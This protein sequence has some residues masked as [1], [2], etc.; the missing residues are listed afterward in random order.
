[1]LTSYQRIMANHR[2]AQRVAPAPAN[3]SVRLKMLAARLEREDA[4]DLSEA[5]PGAVVAL[6]A[7]RAAARDQATA[8]LNELGESV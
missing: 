3:T 2:K 5:I 8:Q 7:S 1:V 6:T 4:R